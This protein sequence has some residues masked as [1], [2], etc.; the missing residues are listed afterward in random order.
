MVAVNKMM[1]RMQI[2]EHDF[3]C[4]L[5]FSTGRKITMPLQNMA[6]IV[7]LIFRELHLVKLHALADTAV[8]F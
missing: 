8:S 5:R 2:S 6:E 1:M 3:H 4:M 7:T